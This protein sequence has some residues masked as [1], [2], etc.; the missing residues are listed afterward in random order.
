[1]AKG[2]IYAL[3][4]LCG[5]P[6]FFV[7]KKDG[8]LCL[9]VDFRVLNAVTKPDAYLILLTNKLL[10]RLKAVKVFTTLD[11]RWGYYNV[12]ICSQQS[13]IIMSITRS[14]FWWSGH[15]SCEGHTWRGTPS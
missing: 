10:D 9:V 4:T 1:M 15:W 11:M 5:A 2:Y 8:T 13:E 14:Y 6:V 3:S 12:R 7:K